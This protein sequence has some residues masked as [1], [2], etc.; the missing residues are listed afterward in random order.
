[1]TQM[2]R[3]EVDPVVIEP[4]ERVEPNY[5]LEHPAGAPVYADW[6][7]V[8]LP[9][10]QARALGVDRGERVAFRTVGG[11]EHPAVVHRRRG[12]QGWTMRVLAAFPQRLVSGDFVCSTTALYVD[13]FRSHSSLDGI[14]TP[15]VP[16]FVHQRTDLVAASAAEVV[17]RMVFANGTGEVVIVWRRERWMHPVVDYAV[18]WGNAEWEAFSGA[19]V[20]F[21]GTEKL[22]LVPWCRF[23]DV[24]TDRESVV[25]DAII[26]WGC[27]PTVWLQATYPAQAEEGPIEE[28]LRAFAGSG[29]PVGRCLTWQLE[30]GTGAQRWGPLGVLPQ[31]NMR[32]A[33]DLLAK[34]EDLYGAAPKSIYAPRPYAQALST[35]QA[36]SQRFGFADGGLAAELLPC[37]AFAFLRVCAQDEELRPVHWFDR[38]GRMVRK[39]D[40]PNLRT[41]NRRIDWRNTRDRLDLDSEPRR[42]AANSRRTA[43]DEQHT[44]DLVADALLNLW[45]DPPLEETRCH[46]VEIEAMDTQRVNG[47]RNSAARGV[48]R[49]LVSMASA[50]WLL[51][52]T[53][54][55][56]LAQAN[57]MAEVH[58]L[59]STWEGRLVNPSH[60]VKP[61][62]TLLSNS[63]A[64]QDP[65]TG[66]PMRAAAPYEH[67]TAVVGLIAAAQC[68]RPAESMQALGLATM[69]TCTVLTWAYQDGP[70]WRWP[71]VV[72]V[73]SEDGELGL[74][75]PIEWTKPSQPEF[76]LTHIPGG[77][78]TDW[79]AAVAFAEA[80]LSSVF[81]G[82]GLMDRV[83]RDRAA[84]I[85]GQYQG[86]QSYLA[87]RMTA[88]PTSVM[89]AA[90]VAA[91]G[92]SG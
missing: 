68:L 56:I 42:V 75:L 25:L 37:Q 65:R 91:V 51:E 29:W 22:E 81:D 46:I 21:P 55:G 31:A 90:P 67:A 66:L 4:P 14:D 11:L 6:V 19:E 30:D 26:D 24:R 54:S 18:R 27:G 60:P 35:N 23:D 69:L 17:E 87:E 49:P 86:Q 36:G 79:T 33:Y 78:W 32:D 2:L 74:A 82:I 62:A 88:L 89:Q 8:L 77:S 45:D 34:T 38:D 61:I 92:V 16:G 52:G 3:L 48:G 76:R 47:Q 58:A 64:L 72:G 43:D 71:F 39:V 10:R 53:D 9:A 28:Q 15:L 12:W 1:M 80:Y 40:H 41:H 50:A 5:E 20:V 13:E 57:L 85:R 84:H 83:L 59:Q 70:S 7:D 73:L 44:D 63:W